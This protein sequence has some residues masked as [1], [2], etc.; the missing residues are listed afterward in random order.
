MCS[1]CI[2]NTLKNSCLSELKQYYYI[3]LILHV[4]IGLID[5]NSLSS[6]LNFYGTFFRYSNYKIAIK[7][8]VSTTKYIQYTIEY[9]STSVY[10]LLCVY[11]LRFYYVNIMSPTICDV[12]Y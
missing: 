1:L 6:R 8:K 2:K 5:I 12:F 7:L 3:L 10:D 11:V 9:L 4:S